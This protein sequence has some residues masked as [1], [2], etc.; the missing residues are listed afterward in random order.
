MIKM[1]PGKGSSGR[2]CYRLYT[3]TFPAFR[4]WFIS[5]LKQSFSEC[6]ILLHRSVFLNSQSTA[7]AGSYAVTAARKTSRIIE[8]L[9]LEDLVRFG[10]VHLY[11]ST[12]IL[13]YAYTNFCRV[14]ALFATCTVLFTLIRRKTGMQSKLAENQMRVCLLGLAEMRDPW[15]VAGWILRL[16]DRITRQSTSENTSDK[17][18][19]S[20]E[21]HQTRQHEQH[22]DPERQQQPTTWSDY[23]LPFEQELHPSRDS[24]PS[25]TGNSSTTERQAFQPD[26]EQIFG[27]GP[28]L[29]S[30][31]YSHFN[32]PDSPFWLNLNMPYGPGDYGNDTGIGFNVME[33]VEVGGQIPPYVADMSTMGL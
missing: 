29:Y 22:Q 33:G 7:N 14:P 23:T 1:I 32:Y 12:A 24:L 30:T 3:S 4:D 31:T 17:N 6:S 15:P 2:G 5:L 26:S 18:T 11:A 27:L 21:S 25:D 20:L 8:E 9:L 16:F 10:Q 28:G 13:Y 19:P